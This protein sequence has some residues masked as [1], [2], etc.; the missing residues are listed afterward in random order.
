MLSRQTRSIAGVLLLNISCVAALR[1]HNDSKADRKDG[2]TLMINAIEKN[3]PV[4]DFKVSHLVK[5]S[6]Y[7][8]ASRIVVLDTHG[9]EP[10][11]AL[12]ASVQGLIARGVVDSY[13]LVNYSEAYLEHAKSRL[14]PTS[15][16]TGKGH[17]G[18]LVYFFMLD[19]CPTRYL[20]HYD[21]DM[22]MWSSPGYSWVREGVQ[23]LSQDPKAFYVTS[24]R[25]GA[26]GPPTSS[27]TCE[28]RGN[29][30]TWVAMRNY[31]MDVGRFSAL[32]DLLGSSFEGVRRFCNQRTLENLLGCA[33]CDVREQGV[34]GFER[35]DLMD[36]AH[37]YALH[38][39]ALTKCGP[40]LASWLLEH[41]IDR[42]LSISRWPGFQ[43]H[44]INVWFDYAKEMARQGILNTKKIPDHC[45]QA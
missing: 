7:P 45:A 30:A 27:L 40:E 41:M 2:A 10:S 17:Q 15:R 33:I 20:V 18:N 34:E 21:L 1:L 42:N 13:R 38:F 23:L 22:V 8:F 26:R 32:L 24:A 4:I 19:T 43:A 28:N 3:S 14:G 6:N 31:L 37:N 35:L 39:P 12:K 11:D 5:Q 16:L 9:E 29:Q 44:H 25:Q 36:G